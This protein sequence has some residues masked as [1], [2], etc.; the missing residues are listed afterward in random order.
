M[1]LNWA[2]FGSSLV[3]SYWNGAATYYRGILRALA[4]RG[5][6]I[7]FYEPDAY[8]RQ[9]HRDIDDPAWARVH[10]YP[11]TQAGASE[12]LQHAREA[13]VLVKASGVGVLDEELEAWIPPLRRPHNRVIFWDVDAPATL[14]RLQQNP[15]DAFRAL[16]PEYDLIFTYGGGP[17]TVSE[18]EALGAR[19]CAPIYNALDRSTHFRIEEKDLPL[20]NPFRARLGLLANRL[21]DREQRIIQFFF[22]TAKRYPEADFL[23]GGSGWSTSQLPKN[24]RYIGHVYSHQH[25]LFNSSVDFVLNVNRASMANYGFSP[26]TR[27]FEAA[28]SGACIITDAWEGIENFLT[29]EKEILLAADTHQVLEHLERIGPETR[30]GIGQAALQKVL[31]NHTYE[32]RVQE[33]E[34]ILKQNGGFE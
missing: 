22:E 33:I 20:E 1:S 31:K 29:P 27:I 5:H 23:L 8:E 7:T 14:Q 32:H 25:N 18:Y 12:A 3:S 17:R 13:D 15:E 16:I 6:R 28:G 11:P 24:V 26:P 30:A 4:E 9:K 34:Q 19:H 2:F 21:P 10:V